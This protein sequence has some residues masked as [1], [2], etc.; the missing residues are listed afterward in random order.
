MP[1]GS[2]RRSVDRNANM[3]AKNIKYAPAGKPSSFSKPKRIKK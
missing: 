2:T 1:V 3:I